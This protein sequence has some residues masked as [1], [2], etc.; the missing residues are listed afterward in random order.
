[1][2]TPFLSCHEFWN[3]HVILF[4]LALCFLFLLG[5]AAPHIF[6]HKL[7]ADELEY[8]KLVRDWQTFIKDGIEHTLYMDNPVL[9]MVDPSSPS[10]AELRRS[11]SS[12]PESPGHAYNSHSY[13]AD[14]STFKAPTDDPSILNA[15]RQ[16]SKNTLENKHIQAMIRDEVF[17]ELP[18]SLLRNKYDK[19]LP[20]WWFIYELFRKLL[21]N[22]F[23]LYGHNQAA[24]IQWKLWVFIVLV[25]SMLV[26]VTLRP[27]Q[28]SVDNQQEAISLTGLLLILYVASTEGELEAGSSSYAWVQAVALSVLILVLVAFTG[29]AR[30][31]LPLIK[32]A[33]HYLVRKCTNKE[34]TPWPEEKQYDGPDEALAK[35][36]TDAR[37]RYFS[38]CCPC[39]GVIYAWWQALSEKDTHE[40]VSIA[41]ELLTD[42]TGLRD[43][44]QARLTPR[45][46]RYEVTLGTKRK[47]DQAKTTDSE[48]ANAPDADVYIAIVGD[49]AHT[50]GVRERGFNRHHETS[51]TGYIRLSKTYKFKPGWAKFE[52]GSY[53]TFT[54]DARDVG[55]IHSI[56][57]GHKARV[58][59]CHSSSARSNGLSSWSVEKI[60]VK[61]IGTQQLVNEWTLKTDTTTM[62]YQSGSIKME[63]PDYW[64]LKGGPAET[65]RPDTPCIMHQFDARGYELRSER[66]WEDHRDK[67]REENLRLVTV[68]QDS[69]AQNQL[70]SNL[71]SSNAAAPEPEPEP[72]SGYVARQAG[73][74][75]LQPS[76][77][78][79]SGTADSQT[80]DNRGA[81]AVQSTRARAASRSTASHDSQPA[82]LGVAAWAEHWSGQYGRPYWV[83]AQTSQSTWRDP[84]A[85]AQPSGPSKT[86]GPSNRKVY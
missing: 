31:K 80:K 20:N 27:Y 76:P 70:H 60:A 38:G 52:P 84:T 9:D 79:G 37:P 43:L 23:Y 58:S 51:H 66:H 12:T 30:D 1:V 63:T 62:K 28:H 10:A 46:V 77:V 47:D 2:S 13:D 56:E 35:L 15:R 24:D 26:N 82:S 85:G 68:K 25:L 3:C 65:G 72:R 81:A 22:V 78:V 34:G 32:H 73:A 74:D 48:P 61:H 36:I 29:I 16:L 50:P 53:L 83:N 55:V 6:Y 19:H 54:F 8:E 17:R 86:S 49:S 67:I 14:D 39:P 75:G 69:N 5:W 4:S 42:T 21:I 11:V 41:E 40:L 71:P 59:V 57:L 44:D 45:T 18:Y 64:K 33:W 7:L